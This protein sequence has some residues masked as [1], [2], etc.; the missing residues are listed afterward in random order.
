M[1][2]P[3]EECSRMCMGD[4]IMTEKKSPQTFRQK[5]YYAQVNISYM[6]RIPWAAVSQSPTC[7]CLT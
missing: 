6:P 2:C 5:S 3:T 4:S 1:A 7:H